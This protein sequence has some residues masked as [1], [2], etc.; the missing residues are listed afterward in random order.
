MTLNITRHSHIRPIV[1]SAIVVALLS[2]VS[3]V[4]LASQTA[5]AED[6]L[7]ISS[8]PAADGSIDKERS[9]FSYQV[10]PG[11]SIS[12]EYFVQ[13]TGSAPQA[14]TIYGTDAYN[15]E[16]GDYALL[17]SG[18]PAQDVGTWVSFEDGSSALSLTLQP[19]ESRVIG[20]TVNVPADASPGDHA[21]GIVVSA[22]SD[23]GQVKLDRRIATRL[24]LRVEGDVQA[25]MTIGSIDASYEPSWNPFSGTVRLMFTITNNGNVSLGAKDVIQ[26]V[27]LFGIPFSG[28]VRDEIP[29]ML[30]GTSRTVTIPV[31]GVGQWMFLTARIDLVATVDPD[32]LTVASLPT[33]KRD[34]AFFA[35][36][37]GLMFSL[38]VILLIVVWRRRKKIRDEKRAEEWLAYAA[39]MAVNEEKPKPAQKKKNPQ[40]D[41]K[42]K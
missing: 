2:G 35:V 4:V 36:P 32:A 41:G 34:V 25:L 30:P 38:V 19:G 28:L 15:S 6:Q 39:E 3:G 21:G 42:E 18:V 31:D 1:V 11:Q 17:D 5:F 8:A 24:Y 26:I 23:S 33:A 16:N 14:V 9:R 37:W 27:G 13:N 22:L 29:E 20:F 40:A 12:D 10:Q 7:S